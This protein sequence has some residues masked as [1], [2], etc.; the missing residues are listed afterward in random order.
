MSTI[1]FRGNQ[2][3]GVCGLTGA[4]FGGFGLGFGRLNSSFFGN[5]VARLQEG[6]EGVLEIL[7]LGREAA[8]SG[9]DESKL[10]PYRGFLKVEGARGGRGRG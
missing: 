3:Y 4:G 6:L 10:L 2:T 9:E 8:K 7:S 1:D 5:G